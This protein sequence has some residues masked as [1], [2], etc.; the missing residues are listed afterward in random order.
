MSI[1]QNEHVNLQL[2]AK[3]QSITKLQAFADIGMFRCLFG[4]LDDFTW[5]DP[6]MLWMPGLSF[7]NIKF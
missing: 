1:S 7:E 6:Q 2:E 5:N 3:L 4:K